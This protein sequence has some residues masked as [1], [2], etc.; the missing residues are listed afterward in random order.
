MKITI[1]S[2]FGKLWSDDNLTND[3]SITE[4]TF[5]NNETCDNYQLDSVANSH[6]FIE[7]ESDEY[8]PKFDQIQIKQLDEQLRNVTSLI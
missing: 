7:N 5:T 8:I 3:S 1:R 4:I 6:D 2:K